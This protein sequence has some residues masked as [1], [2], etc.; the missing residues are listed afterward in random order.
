MPKTLTV[1]RGASDAVRALLRSLIEGGKVEG[2]FTLARVNNKGVGYALIRDPEKIEQAE[3]FYPWMPSS[4]GKQL[5]R[6]VSLSRRPRPLAVVLRPCELRAF[7]ELVKLEQCRRDKLVLI[8]STCGGVYPVE[9]LSDGNPDDRVPR[10]W[11]GLKAG[12]GQPDARDSCRACKHFIPY[13]ADLTVALVGCGDLD[14]KCTF[15]VNSEAGQ[16]CLEG[17]GGVWGQSAVETEA[18]EKLAAARDAERERQREELHLGSLGIEGLV[19]IFGKCV[20][21]RSCREVCPICY[22]TLCDFDSAKYENEPAWFARELNSRKGVRVPPATLLFQM[23]RMVHMSV[24]CVGCGMCSDVCPVNIP[25]ATLFSS[26]GEA[27]QKLFDYVPGKDESQKPPFVK[28][29]LNELE[30]L[31]V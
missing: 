10:Y 29:E 28:A 25:V 18:T 30:N 16:A 14:E 31:T 15:F 20:G 22:C 11:N 8:S 12:E 26:V 17:Q 13:N 23:G 7:V 27:N 3:P 1:N 21:C 9:T 2:V 19:G 5:S 4:G 24:S 6:L